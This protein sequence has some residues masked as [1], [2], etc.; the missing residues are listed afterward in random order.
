MFSQKRQQD[1]PDLKTIEGNLGFTITI[2]PVHYI[3]D[4]NINFVQLFKPQ[5]IS[6]IG[7]VAGWLGPINYGRFGQSSKSK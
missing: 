1:S 2:D 7:Q 3:N 5:M 4:I 6:Y